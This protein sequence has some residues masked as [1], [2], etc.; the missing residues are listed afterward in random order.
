MRT[1]DEIRGRLKHWREVLGGVLKGEETKKTIGHIIEEFEWVL[2]EGKSG[3]GSVRMPMN[4]S[5]GYRSVMKLKFA[6]YS[7]GDI[8]SN[9]LDVVHACYLVQVDVGL[10]ND[11]FA[12]SVTTVLRRVKPGHGWFP[13]LTRLANDGIL[14]K[15]PGR[16]CIG[17]HDEPAY[18]MCDPN[19]VALAL[20]EL[21]YL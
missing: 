15:K 5:L 3:K 9:W 19:G 8:T 16:V 14:N 12:S 10:G 18:T 17:R 4:K 21:G 1:E 6:T 20:H 2:Q 13:S 11:F 7:I